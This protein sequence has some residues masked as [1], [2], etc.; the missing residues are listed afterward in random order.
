MASKLFKDQI[1]IT[2]TKE[3][4]L[5]V[6]SVAASYQFIFRQEKYDLVQ[7]AG[8][9]DLI[10]VKGVADLA[11]RFSASQ[12]HTKL[13]LSK[14][15]VYLFYTML[16]LVCRSFLCDIGDDY[17][18]IAMKIN[19]VSEEHYNSVRNT[20]LMIAQAIIQQIRKDFNE[21]P[22]FEEITERLELLDQ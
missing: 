1:D 15:E 21:D 17:K 2:I 6:R 5:L 3:L 19:K 13:V 22:D 11:A 8:M 7:R 9:L 18:Q 16:E 4:R 12:E 14:E 10:D 20:E